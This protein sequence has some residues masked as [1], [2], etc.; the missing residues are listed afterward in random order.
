M[1][2]PMDA[3]PSLRMDAAVDLHE[4]VEERPQR[5]VDHERPVGDATVAVDLGDDARKK[6]RD[7]ADDDSDRHAEN[8][9]ARPRGDAQAES[10]SRPPREVQRGVRMALASIWRMASRVS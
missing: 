9:A 7:Q 4:V 2:Q 6:A 5:R 3:G 1:V 8:V 10:R